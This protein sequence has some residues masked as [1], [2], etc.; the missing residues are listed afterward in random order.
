MTSPFLSMILFL[1]PRISSAKYLPKILEKNTFVL[2]CLLTTYFSLVPQ[3]SSL[4]IT[5]WATSTSLLVRYPA[6]AVLMAVSVRP[7]LE[8]LEDVTYSNSES[9]SLKFDLMGSSTILPTGS[10][11][12]PLMAA[13]CLTWSFEVLP[14]LALITILIGL[15]SSKASHVLSTKSSETFI[16]TSCVN[17]FFSSV[18]INPWAKFSS[19]LDTSF[20]ASLIIIAFSGKIFASEIPNE[21]PEMVPAQNPKS[22]IASIIT[23][24]SSP[25]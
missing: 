8:P 5:S 9:P 14:T 21:S 11:I 4:T 7:F 20:S 19:I 16:Q 25:V 13:S 15:S 23:A 10:T 18:V 1:E 3:S 2:G 22:L 24:T 17:L 6:S 12:R